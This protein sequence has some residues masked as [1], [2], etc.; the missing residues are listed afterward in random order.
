MT[1]SRQSCT[2]LEVIKPMVYMILDLMEKATCKIS[3]QSSDPEISIT[4]MMPLQTQLAQTSQKLHQVN[5]HC[6][7]ALMSPRLL[8]KALE[9]HSVSWTME[10]MLV[11]IQSPLYLGHVMLQNI[12]LEILSHVPGSRLP[13]HKQGT[14]QRAQTLSRTLPCR[15]TLTAMYI[16]EGTQIGHAPHQPN[17]LLQHISGAGMVGIPLVEMVLF[18]HL[19]FAKCNRS[20]FHS[21]SWCSAAAVSTAINAASCSFISDEAYLILAAY[22]R[23]SS[24]QC[25]ADIRLCSY[26]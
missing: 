22:P 5:G 4:P 6:L 13:I 19:D 24:I 10:T 2:F 9:I 14:F 8:L 25:S 21:C 11:L 17:L 18:K 7:P 12:L 20:T 15:P 26:A 16:E 1:A 3:T 23:G